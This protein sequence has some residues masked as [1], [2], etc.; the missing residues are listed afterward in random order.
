MSELQVQQDERTAA[1]D[2]QIAGWVDEADL[3]NDREWREEEIRWRKAL[4]V[5]SYTERDRRSVHAEAARA[6]K[7]AH[8]FWESIPV[9]LRVRVASEAGLPLDAIPEDLRG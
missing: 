3:H 1:S 8:R 2:E 6:I 7:T 9:G 4:Y 5:G